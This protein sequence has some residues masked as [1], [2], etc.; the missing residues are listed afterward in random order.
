MTLRSWKA[1]GSRAL[2]MCTLPPAAAS[3]EPT[4]WQGAGG[5]DDTRDCVSP[6]AKTIAE[7][8]GSREH[9][10]AHAPIACHLPGLH[11]I[12]MRGADGFRR[13][14]AGDAPVLVQLRH[15]RLNFTL[16]VRAARLDHRLL[17]VP[18]PVEI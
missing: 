11:G 4:I 7:A 8:R 12:E 1:R 2:L 17:S 3:V 15:R 14:L 6:T 9:R 10:V 5:T 18:G 16:V 13:L